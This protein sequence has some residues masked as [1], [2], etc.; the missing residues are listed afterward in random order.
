MCRQRLQTWKLFAVLALGAMN[1]LCVT[2][3][4]RAQEERGAQPE[5]KSSQ[6]AKSRYEDRRG[7]DPNGI[8]RWYHGRQIAQVMG[9]LGAGWLERPERETEEQPN[10]LIKA[11]RLKGNEVIADI[12][13]GSGYFTFRFAPKVPRGKVLAVEIQMEMLDILKERKSVLKIDNVDLIL[14]T[15][16]DPKLG[17]AVDLV[18]MVD[19]YHEFNQPFEMVESMVKS[20]K[21]G[22]RIAF[23]EYRMEDPAVPIKTVH[24]M[25]EKQL[26]REMKDHP[27]LEHDETIETLPWQHIILFKKKAVTP[28]APNSTKE[29]PAK[30]ERP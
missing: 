13:A 1:G 27:L 4:V 7:L 11:L 15:E 21:P 22:G 30:S 18:V 5:A 20:L 8:D 9:H 29:A 28:G 14:G 24:K 17:S 2:G 3:M 6:P 16:S 12:G 10:K 19:V 23:V 25:S 26:R